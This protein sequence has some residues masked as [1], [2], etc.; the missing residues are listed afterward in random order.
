MSDEMS[1]MRSIL[2]RRVAFLGRNEDHR[3]NFLQLLRSAPEETACFDDSV[4]FFRRQGLSRSG[5]L[6]R[7]RRWRDQLYGT[8]DWPYL[9][10]ILGGIDSAKIDCVVGYWGTRPLA[11]LIAI[12]RNRPHVRVVL[13][14]LC[15]PLGQT[16]H[17]VI[18]QN[19]VMGRATRFL[20][21]LILPSEGMQNYF[22]R[23]VLRR[24]SVPTLISP[25]MLAR[26]YHPRGP[27]PPILPAPN[28]VFLGRMGPSSSI[29]PTDD[30]GA[31]LAELMDQGIDVYHH[32]TSVPLPV[33]PR[34]HTFDYQPLTQAIN[35]A[36]Q[37]DASLVLYNTD[38]S[39]E[40]VRF[41]VTVPD[42]LIASVAAGVPI[43]IPRR[44][45]DAAKQYLRNYRS[46]IEYTSAAELQLILSDRARIVDLKLLAERDR[47]NYSAE[48]HRDELFQFLLQILDG[49]VPGPMADYRPLVGAVSA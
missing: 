29:Q 15:H 33:H 20:D 49:K 14:V 10:Y 24:H 3:A 31:Q 28:V 6:A 25:P 43:A 17:A 12:K 36:R 27:N 41:R 35:A 44:G 46:V 8:D 38:A 40:G 39:R 48:T 42:R 26:A 30:V 19:W 5:P 18:A 13:N 45:Y 32:T 4:T 22:A 1:P 47:A 7:I 37:F 9:D 2:G 34:R 23:R 21:G 16:R 11:D